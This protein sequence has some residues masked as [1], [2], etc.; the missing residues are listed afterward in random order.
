MS[1]IADGAV[2]VSHMVQSSGF[3]LVNIKRLSQLR[4]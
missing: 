1:R 4:D 2:V 3:T